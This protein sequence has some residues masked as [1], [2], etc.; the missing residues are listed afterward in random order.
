MTRYT[1]FYNRCGMLDY[2]NGRRLQTLPEA[3]RFA[4]IEEHYRRTEAIA[5]AY[6]ERGEVVDYHDPRFETGAGHDKEKL[7]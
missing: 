7:S 5:N 6:G 1:E 2:H 4:I 3:Q